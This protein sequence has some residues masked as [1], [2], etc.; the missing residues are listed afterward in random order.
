MQNI[1]MHKYSFFSIERTTKHRPDIF[2]VIESS[3]VYGKLE[4]WRF[5]FKHF[6]E[7]DSIARPQLIDVW[8]QIGSTID[9]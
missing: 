1:I 4:R 7:D 6:L 9:V 2:K 8:P 5:D 3:L